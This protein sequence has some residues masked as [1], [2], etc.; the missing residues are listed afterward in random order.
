MCWL[1]AVNFSFGDFMDKAASPPCIRL[2]FSG[3]YFRVTSFLGIGSLCV[4]ELIGSVPREPGSFNDWGLP[5]NTFASS[6]FF[7][8]VR[9]KKEALRIWDAVAVSKSGF[10]AVNSPYIM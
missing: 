7:L 6:S 5:F 10:G 3:L 1:P 2:K 8:K 9:V 4:I